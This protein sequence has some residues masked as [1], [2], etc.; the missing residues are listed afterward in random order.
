[1][2]QID[3]HVDRRIC[4][5]GYLSRRGRS[6]DRSPIAHRCR[7]RSPMAPVCDRWRPSTTGS[8]PNTQS[9]SDLIDLKCDFCM[10]LLWLLLV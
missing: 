7:A 2:S 6:F 10:H 8:T 1:M 3:F 5:Y 4:T 9:V